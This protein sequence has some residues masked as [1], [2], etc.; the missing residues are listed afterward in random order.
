MAVGFLLVSAAASFGF[1]VARG[2][3]T[4]PAATVAALEPTDSP[5]AVAAAPTGSPPPTSP[6]ETADAPSADPTPAATPAPTT[7][8]APEPTPV[9]TPPPTATPEPTP[10]PTPPPTPRPTATP[11]PRYA[12]LEPCRDQPGC[13]VYTVRSGDSLWAIGERFGH[14]LDTVYEWNPWTRTR[15]LRPGAE[16]LLPP[17][18]A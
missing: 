16:I 3:L 13:W 17:P 4:M 9:P 7:A 14:S 6:A 12:D 15:G 2:G 11:Q 10:E 8:P 5:A 18:N 1:V